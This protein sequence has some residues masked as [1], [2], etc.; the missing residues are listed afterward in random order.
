MLV[1]S[2]NK[3]SKADRKCF[4][5]IVNDATGGVRINLKGREPHGCVEPGDEYD[6]LCHQLA[7]DLLQVRN[8]ETGRPLVR[9]I[10]RPEQLYSGARVG[11]LPDLLVQWNRD[12]PIAQVQSPKTGTVLHKYQ[13]GRTGDHRP[14][15]ILFAHGSWVKPG[16]IGSSALPVI[17]LAPTIAALLGVS[18]PNIDGQPI[19]ALSSPEQLV[20]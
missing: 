11:D 12:A 7:A 14:E 8:T 2:T 5:V 16:L 19:Q 1:R 18:L 13:S 17:D 4:E 6:K 9:A 15:G 10:R 20:A 3:T